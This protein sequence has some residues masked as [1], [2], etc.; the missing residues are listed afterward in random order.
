[1]SVS[2]FVSSARFFGDEGVSTRGK[3]CSSH[4]N[5]SRVADDETFVALDIFIRRPMLCKMSNTEKWFQNDN[6][7]RAIVR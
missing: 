1:M 6:T 5:S 4:I 2:Q 7:K 3:I